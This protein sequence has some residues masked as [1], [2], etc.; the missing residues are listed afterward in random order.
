MNNLNDS[1]K[2]E[3]FKNKESLGNKDLLVG[4]LVAAVV[5]IGLVVAVFSLAL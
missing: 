5:T 2:H 3:E 1:T 4:L